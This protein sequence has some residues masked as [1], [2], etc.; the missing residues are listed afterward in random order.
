MDESPLF[1]PSGI[2]SSFYQD[3]L[4]GLPDAVWVG[5]LDGSV[6]YWNR[7]AERL[8]GYRRDQAV[9]RLGHE[10][11]CSV[12]AGSEE[13][14]GDEGEEIWSGE[15]H[16]T[17]ADGR[18]LTVS[19]RRVLVRSGGRRLV[20]EQSREVTQDRSALRRA[21]RDAEL[22]SRLSHDLGLLSDPDEVLAAACRVTGEHLDVL[23]C[24]FSEIRE[25]TGELVVS[26]DWR[27][28]GLPSVA[29]AYRMADYLPDTVWQRGASTES[30]AIEDVGTH[31]LSRDRFAAY[32]HLGTRSFA[33]APFVRAGRWAVMLI[34]TSD[35]PRRW[36]PEELALLERAKAGDE[37]ALRDIYEAHQ[38]QVRGHLHRHRQELAV[39]PSQ[40]RLDQGFQLVWAGH[41][42][43]VAHEM[44]GVDPISGRRQIPSHAAVAQG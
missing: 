31:P 24:F 29:G 15:L 44:P 13:T 28:P 33:T 38:S 25:E 1:E 27:R 3:L 34:V 40:V 2:G 41:R 9:G 30:F 20:L 21:E 36:Q 4:E 43:I 8:Y 7:A 18:L 6:V 17:A 12:A 39:I 35:Q 14:H 22:L 5:E 26:S 32:A 11:L 23:R 42:Q 37:R 16:R 19:S 10:L